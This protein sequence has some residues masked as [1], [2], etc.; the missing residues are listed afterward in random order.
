MPAGPGGTRLIN[1]LNGDGATATPAG[2]HAVDKYDK[3][4]YEAFIAA[5]YHGFSISNDWYVR[6]LDS[7]KTPFDGL[8][9][10]IYTIPVAKNGTTN[11]LFPA[12][13]GLLD[14]G[15]V[16]QG[17]YFVIP[18]KLEFVA[19]W[20][21][22]RG[23]S[24]DILGNGKFTTT[25]VPGVGKVNVVDGACR[26][27]H[28]ANEYTVGVNYYFRRQLLKWQTDF[29]YYHGGNPAGA[30]VSPAGFIAG[31]DGWL[32]RTQIQLAF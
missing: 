10:I 3:F 16:L 19:R 12:N 31:S 2:A 11:A 29:G 4:V 21:W 17:G 15:Q 1:V 14:Y 7:F 6:N 24:G 9:N 13:H 27:F 30:G 18:K 25:T 5:K 23:D 26:Q 32:L 20:S 8:G 22:I 28:E